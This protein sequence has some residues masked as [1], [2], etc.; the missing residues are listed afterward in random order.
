M[1]KNTPFALAA[2]TALLGLSISNPA[3]ANEPPPP[4]PCVDLEKT[5]QD[6]ASPT[7]PITYEVT[8]SN[9]GNMIIYCNVKDLITREIVINGPVSPGETVGVSGSYYLEEC[10]ESTNE[11][12]A[13]CSYKISPGVL[14][15]IYDED[16]ATCSVPC[17]GDNGCTLTPGYWKTHSKYGPAPYDDTWALIGEDTIFFLSGLSFYEVLWTEPSGGNAYFILAHA[18]IAAQLNVLNGASTPSDVATAL[19]D[20][21]ALF[22]LYTP[23][24]IGALS[25]NDPV[26]KS[27]VKLAETLDDYNNGL[28]G[29]GHCDDDGNGDGG[30]CE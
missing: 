17:D 11:V 2:I 10:G 29:P 3:W 21:T 24:D 23:E 8:I 6:A 1:L 7:D 16:F 19:S 5:C 15:R 18:Y 12:H 22:G 13:Q 20:A 28:S 26:R 4:A 27:F 25:G 9:C 30:V 14:G